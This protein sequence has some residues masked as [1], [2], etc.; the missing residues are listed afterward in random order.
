MARA[1]AMGLAL[2][3]QRLQRYGSAGDGHREAIQ[4]E[5]RSGTI[6]AERYPSTNPFTVYL[7][8]PLI[9]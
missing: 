8:T 6:F 3:T 1:G 2:G 5:A 7:V 4:G 9:A